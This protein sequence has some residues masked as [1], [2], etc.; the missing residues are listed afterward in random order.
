[1]ELSRRDLLKLGFF[2][3]AAL[4][5]P[6][7]RIARTELAVAN[8][9]P[10]SQLPKPFTVPF[11][12]P[13]VAVPVARTADTDLY[14]LSQVQAPAEILPGLTTP[15][16]GYNGITPGPTIVVPQ[17]R[18]TL[19]RQLCDL[20]AVHPTLRYN[21]WTST[22]LHGSASLPEFDGYASDFTNPGEYKD[23]QYPNFQEARTLWYHDHGVHITA[24]NAYMGLAAFY[25]LH[26]PHELALPIPHGVYDLPVVVKDAMFT[27]TGE[28]IFDDGGGSGM[29][30][31][32]I[33]ANGRPWPAMPVERRKYR[34]RFLNASVSR[35]YRLAL[36]TGDPFTVI[37]TDGG[38]MPAPA[39]TTSLRFGMAERY[40][41]VIDF[42]KYPIGTRV[43]LQNLGL[44]NNIDFDTTSVIMAF[45]V[46]A[47]AT[48]PLNNTIPPVLNPDDP[49]MRLT[50]DQ[51]VTTRRME[52]KRQGGEWTIN[53]QTW[54][55]VINSGFTQVIASPKLGDVEI[56]EL[57][58][59]SNGWFHPVHI[60]L[61]DFKILDR[62]GQPPLP[63]EHGPKDVVYVGEGETV[64]VL[65][66]FGP[67]VG[68]YMMHCH[69][70]VHEDHDMMVQFEVGANGH[71]PIEGD[72][73]KHQPAPELH[74]DEDRS[75][76]SPTSG[77]SPSSGAA[78][79][80]APPQPG[81]K[82]GSVKPKPKPKRKVKVKGTKKRK[83][84]AKA[85]RK[86]KRKPK[87]K[88]KP[89]TRR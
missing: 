54:E 9:I 17:G 38:L 18:K 85:K 1:M 88:R 19:V 77:S 61:V 7:E 62:N 84:K 71:D 13:P 56:W 76:P 64:R 47:E 37:G 69:N 36:S 21:V 72:R 65:M 25:I 83:R 23:Y 26:D 55:D 68:R 53:G 40:E 74:G 45:D 75:G 14:S 22:H 58:N 50:A 20:P 51:A 16:W 86:P 63:Y 24:P 73:P 28:L 87:A 79:T 2:G 60:H 29:F 11:A 35:S 41:I 10:A 12:V 59:N 15:I 42:A 70:L 78:P 52:F 44:P 3:S 4:M 46:A 57:Q 31:D 27:N 32:V 80:A 6:A 39:E 48:N 66:R 34:F 5:L 81:V 33:L 67:Q 8:R 89:G 49:A 82:V 43:V 30:G